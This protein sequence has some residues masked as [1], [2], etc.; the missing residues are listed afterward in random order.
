MR[1][2]LFGLVLGAT[3]SLWASI[4]Y[5]QAGTGKRD[6]YLD[7]GV[8][9][10]GALKEPASLLNIRRILAKNSVI[11]RWII[12]L[13]DIEGKPLAHRPSY[14]H[15]AIDRDM[16]RIVVDL[17]GVATSKIDEEQIGKILSS[18]PYVKSVGLR[19]DGSE[20]VT[21]LTVL[22]KRSVEVE[23]FELPSK[24]LGGR[25]ALDVRP[26]RTTKR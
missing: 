18:S 19:V 26:T 1:S 8:F 11:D 14:F 5:K 10:G 3:C 24:E 12:D 6:I 9:T 4:P 20:K 13:G 15:I 7:N 21:H 16:K 25:I 2:L 23:A 22:L 17:D